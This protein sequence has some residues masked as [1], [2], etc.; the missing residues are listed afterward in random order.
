MAVANVF[1]AAEHGGLPSSVLFACTM[2][3]VRSPMAAGILKHLVGPSLH[4]ESAGVHRGL[5]DPLVADVMDEIGIGIS[6]H[7][8]KR[9]E[10]LGGQTFDLVISLSPEAH[11]KSLEFTREM[12][13]NTEYWPTLDATATGDA[14][15]VERQMKAYRQV[16]DQL[17]TRVKARFK[18]EGGPTV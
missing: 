2:N 1:G 3:A 11:H 12:N 15:D 13:A 18:L 4:V 8:S 17:F 10:D 14:I 16:R 9:F 7:R 6:Y 5:H